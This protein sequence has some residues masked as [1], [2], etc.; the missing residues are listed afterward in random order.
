MLHG[1]CRM[2]AAGLPSASG[3]GRGTS[4]AA[5]RQLSQHARHA[6]LAAPAGRPARKDIP[7]H[8][9]V[10]A[11]VCDY[12]THRDPGALGAFRS[13]QRRAAHHTARRHTVRNRHMA[14]RGRSPQYIALNQ[15]TPSVAHAVALHMLSVPALEA[16]PRLSAERLLTL[17]HAPN[18]CPSIQHSRHQLAGRPGGRVRHHMLV[19]TMV[20]PPAVLQ[21]ARD[22][23]APRVRGARRDSVCGGATEGKAFRASR[24]G[25]VASCGVWPCAYRAGKLVANVPIKGVELEDVARMAMNVQRR[26]GIALGLDA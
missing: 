14:A 2:W 4:P 25:R 6:T 9:Q 21:Q 13:T 10:R 5:R 19:S 16:T 12:A 3:D 18:A 1:P 23:A 7:R 22:G 26:G 11:A 17:A 8:G 20:L 24:A 15:F